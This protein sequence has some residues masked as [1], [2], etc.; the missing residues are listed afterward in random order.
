[1]CVRRGE[2]PPFSEDDVVSMM[3]KGV[4]MMDV[5]MNE[6]IY[7]NMCM[8]GNRYMFLKESMCI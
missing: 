1:M 2:R 6:D 8:N 3:K 5:V 4:A 7:M